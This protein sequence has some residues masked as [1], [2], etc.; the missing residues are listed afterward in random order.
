MVS[1]RPRLRGPV[2]LQDPACQFYTTKM[3]CTGTPLSPHTWLYICTRLV[4]TLDFD[5]CWKEPVC[6]NLVLD[7]YHFV[8]AGCYEYGQV[9][10]IT[11]LPIMII[12]RLVQIPLLLRDG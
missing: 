3:R 12:L 10:Y 6:A 4:C 8:S 5:P 11:L 1:W 2:L 9:I 7:S